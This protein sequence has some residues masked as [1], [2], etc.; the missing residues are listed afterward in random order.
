[1]CAEEKFIIVVSKIYISLASKIIDTNKDKVLPA[2]QS[3]KL[4]LNIV[5]YLFTCLL[6]VRKLLAHLHTHH[7]E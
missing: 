2:T 5:G 4:L 6:N 3:H 1:M 7:D